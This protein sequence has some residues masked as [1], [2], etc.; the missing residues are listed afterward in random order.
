[1][2]MDLPQI[3]LLVVITIVS[4]VLITIGIQLIGLLKDAKE[5]LR[6]ADLVLEDLGFLTRNIT[7]GGTAISG[8]LDSFKSGMQLV[9]LFSKLVTPKTKKV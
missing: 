7:R 3:L 1:M 9:G 2:H 8:L 6:K 5:T 4:V